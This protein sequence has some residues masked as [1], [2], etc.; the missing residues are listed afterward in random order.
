[1]YDEWAKKRQL[2]IDLYLN[3]PRSFVDWMERVPA[4][5]DNVPPCFDFSNVKWAG[6]W[7]GLHH[8]VNAN[9]K[10]HGAYYKRDEKSEKVELGFVKEGRFISCKFIVSRFPTAD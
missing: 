7:K 1:M 4:I 9:G 10:P 3:A 6:D 5:L 2:C 8:M